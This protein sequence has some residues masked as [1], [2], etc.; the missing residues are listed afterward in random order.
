HF[1]SGRH[2]RPWIG[3]VYA[4]GNAYA[5]VEPLESTGLMMIQRAICGLVRS[6]PI[7]PSSQTMR[8]Y[9]NASIARHWDRLRWFLAAH[10]KFNQRLDTPFWRDVRENADITGLESALEM[11]RA[12]GPLSLLPRALQDSLEDDLGVF[13]YGLGGLDCI[14]L[15]QK[16]PHRPVA[17]EPK[18]A[19]RSRQKL[20][21]DFARRG[22]RY[23]EALRAIDKHP[24]WLEQVVGTPTGWVTKMAETL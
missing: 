10:Y 22:L 14:L 5:F 24:E 6:F 13:F 23:A 4:V 7:G 2:E 19:W 17:I 18:A 9:V 20:A 1:R 21:Q 15:G 12:H 3:N 16:V 8:K 11:Y